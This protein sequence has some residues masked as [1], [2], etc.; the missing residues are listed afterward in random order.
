MPEDFK[1]VSTVTLASAASSLTFDNIP[2][3][4]T[5]LYIIASTHNTGTSGEWNGRVTCNGQECGEYIW[6]TANAGSSSG[7][8]GTGGY[9]LNSSNNSD[10]SLFYST[11]EIRV[12]NYAGTNSGNKVIEA[13]SGGTHSAAWNR[14]FMG[15]TIYNSA[16]PITTFTLNAPSGVNFAANTMASLYMITK[17]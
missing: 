3:T 5:D 8:E 15:S 9:V 11:E 17:A 13:T 16:S 2:Q 12:Y 1:H 7:T 6:L 4:G 14:K 10:G